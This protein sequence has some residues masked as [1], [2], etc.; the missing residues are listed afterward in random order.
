MLHVPKEA[1]KTVLNKITVLVGLANE[2]IGERKKIRLFYRSLS[3]IIEMRITNNL[4]E[5]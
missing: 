5:E 4:G 2:R 3:F 1:H